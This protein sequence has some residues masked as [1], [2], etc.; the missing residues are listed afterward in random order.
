MK[1]PLLQH[2]AI[3]DNIYK[4]ILKVITTLKNEVHMS[5]VLELK[6]KVMSRG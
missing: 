2:I 1:P 6:C 3:I 5:M 4:S